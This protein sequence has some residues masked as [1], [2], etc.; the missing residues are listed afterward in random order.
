MT[1]IIKDYIFKDHP[2][3]YPTP[4]EV[5]HTQN[6]Q[7]DPTPKIDKKYLNRV[8]QAIKDAEEGR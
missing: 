8:D 6:A 1:S 5:Q 7:A 3:E 4:P 2:D